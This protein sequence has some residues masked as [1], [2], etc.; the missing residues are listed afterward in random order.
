MENPTG[1]PGLWIVVGIGSGKFF[2]VFMLP[3]RGG[4]GANRRYRGLK[5]QREDGVG[6]GRGDRSSPGGSLPRLPSGIQL[7]GVQEWLGRLQAV[8]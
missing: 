6:Y 4:G 7:L 1:V 8:A 3:P 2:E 5:F